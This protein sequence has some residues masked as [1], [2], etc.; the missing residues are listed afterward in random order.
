MRKGLKYTIDNGVVTLIK[1]ID[2]LVDL[3]VKEDFVIELY[4]GDIEVA[5]EQVR[6]LV[7][8]SGLNT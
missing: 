2:S 3:L 5:E 4:D 7:L 8:E 6:F 1:D